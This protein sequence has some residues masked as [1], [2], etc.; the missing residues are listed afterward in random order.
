M[1]SFCHMEIMLCLRMSRFPG[2]PS[3]QDIKRYKVSAER[4]AAQ[5]VTYT[6]MHAHKHN[7][8][9]MMYVYRTA[10]IQ[11]TNFFEDQNL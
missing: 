2:V 5:W 11:F 6:H 10:L 3:H 9:T 8:L 4:N 7:F 1:F